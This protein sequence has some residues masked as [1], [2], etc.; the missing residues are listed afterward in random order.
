M[1][2]GLRASRGPG[3]TRITTRRAL[4]SPTAL[5]LVPGSP[6]DIRHQA[7]DLLRRV[8]PRAFL[9]QFPDVRAADGALPGRERGDRRD[10]RLDPGL[11]AA[12]AASRYAGL[13]P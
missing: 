3:M 6:R 13:H 5:G 4:R 10:R 9:R 7:H 12:R 11:A 1:D 8:R 2:S